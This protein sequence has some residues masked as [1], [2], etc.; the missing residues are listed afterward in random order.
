MD[1]I[2]ERTADRTGLSIYFAPGAGETQAIWDRVA[3]MLDPA[4][5]G[6]GTSI[7]RPPKHEPAGVFAQLIHHR[8]PTVV[9]AHSLGGVL[10]LQAARANPSI[11]GLVLVSTAARLPIGLKLSRLLR[12][13]VAAGL[14]VI[15]R[16]AV[17]R[18]A[19]TSVRADLQRRF[20]AMAGEVGPAAVRAD[21]AA[22]EAAGSP[23]P[24][25]AAAPASVVVSSRDDRLV[26]WSLGCA[27][28]MSLQAPLRLVEGGGHLLPWTEPGDVA[29]AIH[30]IV[31][32]CRTKE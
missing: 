22:V 3:S 30:H 14:D 29:D 9:A 19:S 13:D 5:V 11:I 18:H 28:A 31:R 12:A 10:A 7:V 32:R 6:A 1:T 16:A 15:A 17:P 26:P 2:D 23:W 4:V 27:L 8:Q 20:L 24:A 21:F 25:M